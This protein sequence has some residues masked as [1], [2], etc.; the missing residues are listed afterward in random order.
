MTQAVEGIYRNGV[1][2]LL[3]V[4]PDIQESRVLV[5]F[6]PSEPQSST[7]ITLGMFKGDRQSTVADFASA[8][9]HPSDPRVLKEPWDLNRPRFRS[10]S[11]FGRTNSHSGNRF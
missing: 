5:T 3:E 9:F 10:P 1:I 11:G 2:E 4:P 8:E 6:L 7:M